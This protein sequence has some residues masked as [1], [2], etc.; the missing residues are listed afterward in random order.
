MI[1]LARKIVDAVHDNLFDR[2][3]AWLFAVALVTAATLP[4]VGVGDGSLLL[5]VFITGTLVELVLTWSIGALANRAPRPGDPETRNGFEAWRR[6]DRPLHPSRAV[7]AVA[8]G[9]GRGRN[10]V[11]V[12][13]AMLM[14][15]ACVSV[16]LWPADQLAG[17][18][19]DHP[20]PFEIW[21]FGL[22]VLFAG[23]LRLWAVRVRRLSD[24]V[25]A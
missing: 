15:L 5:V 23:V 14:A 9:V 13:V 8:A 1:S 2:L 3:I 18:W 24:P 16:V 25:E 21:R 20:A 4:L 6:P 17:L 22:V 11:T 10:G 7:R 19:P 12:W